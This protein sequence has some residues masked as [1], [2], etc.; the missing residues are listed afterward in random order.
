MRALR[1]SVRT[2]AVLLHLLWGSLLLAVRFR[3]VAPDAL[4]I[5]Q[6]RHRQRWCQSLY[7]KLGVN[8]QVAGTP[9]RGGVLVVCNH[10]SWLDILLL[11]GQTGAN[12]LAKADLQRWPW[13]GWMIARGGTLFIERGRPGAATAAIAEIRTRLAQG[14]AV[15]VFP[16]GTTTD[17]THMKRFN[18]RLLQAAVEAG[19]PVQPVGLTYGTPDQPEPDVPFI[20]DMTFLRSLGRIVGKP[21]IAA[22][23]VF[24]DPLPSTGCSR[25]PLAEAAEAQIRA[26][27][28]GEGPALP[29]PETATLPRCE[30]A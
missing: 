3:G 20:G 12:F 15:V 28:C 11:A 2:T 5:D 16:E 26:G 27:R 24:H 23:L 29:G 21:S 8:L 7:S 9:A 6:H 18:P 19:V 14:E 30:V 13:L 10:I 17:G 22:S 1:A 4:G 25:R